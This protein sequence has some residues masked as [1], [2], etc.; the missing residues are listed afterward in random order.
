[1]SEVRVEADELV[2]HLQT[3]DALRPA[4]E[5]IC[6]QVENQAKRLCPVGTP[7]STGK[8]GYM[9]GR[10]RASIN[11]RVDGEG[12][13]GSLRGVIGSGARAGE[14][15]VNYAA[16]VEFGTSRMTARPYLRPALT[17]VSQRLASASAASTGPAEA[18]E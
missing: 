5:G 7:E 11:H 4:L 8:R 6:Q 17:M 14:T 1:M 15:E 9:G 18:A 16:Y 13:G 10:L 12:P 3:S 2:A